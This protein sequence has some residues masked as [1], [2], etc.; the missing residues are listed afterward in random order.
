MNHLLSIIR[1]ESV[2]STNEFAQ[3]YAIR[4]PDEGDFVVVANEQSHGK[5]QRGN[6]WF[7]EKDK[8]L[9]FSLVK[10]NIVYPADELFLVNM[11][12]SL[13]L[14][15]TVSV[16]LSPLKIKWPNDLYFGYKKIAGIL[17]ENSIRGRRISQS[18]IG[19]GINVNQDVFPD[20]LPRA[21][22]ILTESQKVQDRERILQLF[23]SNFER[24]FLKK[25]KFDILKQHYMKNLLGYQ[26]V[27]SYKDARGLFDGRIVDIEADGRL[28]LLDKQDVIRKYLF[29]EVELIH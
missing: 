28:C 21:G 11:I 6:T 26:C 15:D 1:L 29:K 7:S 10:Q 13:A 23:I 16:L 19:I 17:V 3:K 14:F 27:L 2:S 24:Y 5:G 18:I 9:C 8:N 4:H 20:D 25:I 12:V 22:S